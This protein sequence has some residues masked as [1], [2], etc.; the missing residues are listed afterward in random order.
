[1]KQ[2]F[3]RKFL[4]TQEEVKK[5]FDKKLPYACYKIVQGYFWEEDPKKEFRIRVQVFDDYN[6]KPYSTLTI[7]EI[8][9][10]IFNHEGS[11]REE[12]EINVDNHGAL[13]HLKNTCSK[14]LEKTR[15]LVEWKSN[16]KLE[17]N[18]LN[19]RLNIL[20]IEFLTKEDMLNYEP[21]FD[22]SE[23]ITNERRYYSNNMASEYS[24]EEINHMI[25]FIE[26]HLSINL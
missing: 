8:P 5:I 25:K 2:E 6:S 23:E 3:E 20:E 13:Y 15:Y 21:D 18:V 16:I 14:F 7:K 9:E 10:N 19:E 1:M 26:D 4:M 24:K 22:Y 17:I 11:D 12:F